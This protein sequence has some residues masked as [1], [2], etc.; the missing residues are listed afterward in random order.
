MMLFVKSV[1]VILILLNLKLSISMEF[2]KWKLVKRF[3]DYHQK[4]LSLML[5]NWGV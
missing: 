4:N 2:V 3:V 1:A 5:I